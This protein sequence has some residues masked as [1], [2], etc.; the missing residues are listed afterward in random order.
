MVFFPSARSISLIRCC[1]S[2]SSLSGTTSSFV[3]TAAA[4]PLLL[5]CCYRRTTDGEIANSR[6]SSEIVS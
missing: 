1:A 2:R 4:L 3:L 6:A 5:R